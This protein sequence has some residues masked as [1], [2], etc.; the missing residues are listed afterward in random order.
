[1]LKVNAAG[2]NARQIQK[3]LIDEL[4]KV[5]TK[6][7]PTYD[8]LAMNVLLLCQVLVEAEEYAD[9]LAAGLPDGILPKDVEILREANAAFASENHELRKVIKKLNAMLNY[10]A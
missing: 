4:N 5:G 9:K 2:E 1:M 8:D 3:R 6:D 10:Y 7:A